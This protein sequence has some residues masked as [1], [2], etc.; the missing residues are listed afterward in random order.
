VVSNYFWLPAPRPAARFRLY[1]L[2]HAGAG[3]SAFGRWGSA[4]PRDIEIAAIQ[5]PGR[6]ARMDEEPFRRFADAAQRI[7]EAIAGADTRP[8]ALFGHSA[9]AKLAAHVALR[10]QATRHRPRRLFISAGPISVAP[11]TWLHRL[12]G[13]HFSAAVSRKF[14][15]LPPEITADPELWQLF[16]AP[17][18]ADLE[19]LETDDLTALHLDVPVTVISGAR[20]HVAKPADLEAWRACAD[21]V[22][23]ASVDADH[24]SY[25]TSP[26]A[27]LDV[28]A[29]QLLAPQ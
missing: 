4:A 14:G 17:L 23:Y 16:E 24:Y 25:R 8:L 3:A 11:D 15:A 21:T 9:G 27:Y 18:R 28:I 26:G 10:L 13:A 12:D 6:E 29:R 5:L 2:A 1:C 7:G 22:V 19:A 20:D